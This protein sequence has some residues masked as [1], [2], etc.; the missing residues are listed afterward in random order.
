MSN[1]NLAYSRSMTADSTQQ[2][3]TSR[4]HETEEKPLDER[5]RQLLNLKQNKYTL[6]RF[7]GTLHFAD[8]CE[9][10]DEPL[11]LDEA[12][13]CFT[14]MSPTQAS[15]VLPGLHEERQKACLLAMSPSKASRILRQMANDDAVDVLQSLSADE[16][17]V[18]LGEMPLDA[19]TRT[20]HQL[21]IEAPDT[22]AGLMSTDF[23]RLPLT[24]TVGQAMHHIRQAE[25]KDFIYYLYLVDEEERLKAVVSLKKLLIHQQE[26]TL[27]NHLA[28]YD[29]KS[30]LDSFDQELVANLFRKY[31][32][33]L[34]VPVVDSADRLLGI[35][36]LD[37]VVDV[38]DEE[39]QEDIYKSSGILLEEVSD[40]RHLL[41][42][43][44]LGAVKARLPWLSVTL[45]GQFFGAAIIAGFQG[46]VAQ[47]VI[48]FSFLPLLSGLSGNVGAQSDTIAVRGL[49]LEQLH[50][51]NIRSVLWR[52]FRVAAVMGLTFALAI[53][54]TAFILYRHWQLSSLLFA[55]ILIAVCTSAL[56]GISVAYIIKT[57]FK[58]D[59]AGVGGPFITTGVDLILYGVYLSVLTMLLPS[60]I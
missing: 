35:I 59:P 39:L 5:I 51:D 45:V 56:S 40:E 16:R 38:I 58:K 25:E 33:L 32:N 10:L 4:L 14:Y 60:M 11:T 1:R 57:V 8:L 24:T 21:L 17:R 27:L 55:F 53:G 19:D 41:S 7:L 44:M 52:E 20:I 29:V 18:I 34:S 26:E 22:A 36:T 48:A 13:A 46:T 49:A 2:A 15:R 37:D 42:G 31:Y 43:P 30:V 28:T 23:I 50:P 9:A 6:R 3:L 54:G 12:I 47:A